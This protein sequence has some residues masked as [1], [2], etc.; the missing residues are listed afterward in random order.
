MLFKLGVGILMD[1]SFGKM[2][3]NVKDKDMDIGDVVCY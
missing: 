1:V 2:N 3:G